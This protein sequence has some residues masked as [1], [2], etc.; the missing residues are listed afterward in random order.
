MAAIRLP[1]KRVEKPWGRIK[2]WEGFEDAQDDGHPIGEIWFEAPGDVELLVKYLFT[3]EKLSVQ[4]H[5][6]D[7]FARDHGFRRGKDEAWLILEADPGAT[8]AL[9]T[10]EVMSREELR[11][12]A[13]DGLIEHKLF[14]KAVKTGDVLYSPA[15][16]IHAIGGG[17]TLI[18]VQQ[19]VDLTYRLYDYGSERELN[20]D[21]GIAVA[22]PT[23]YRLPAICRNVSPGRT[24]VAEGGKFVMER[25]S[26][27]HSTAIG[28]SEVSVW[29]IP[30]AG[31]GSV[32]G[33]VL[34]AGGVWL[35]DGETDMELSA[36]AEL[37]VAY[38]VRSS[39]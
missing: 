14:W 24:V 1:M 11:A 33:E 39:G 29:I 13:L 35:V 8:I 7:A 31:G 12:A 6:D 17:L 25:W 4:V 38:P 30:L 3:A 15:G 20:L 27:A 9:G 23:P 26:G 32:G 37:L 18:E 10:L 22:D 16:T 2:L 5:P 34:E 21:D 19:N 28:S 36:D